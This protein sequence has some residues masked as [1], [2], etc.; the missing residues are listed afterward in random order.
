MEI[1]EEYLKQLILRAA[2]EIR[3]ERLLTSESTEKSE[4]VDALKVKSSPLTE[5][6]KPCSQRYWEQRRG[7]S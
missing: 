4:Y 2:N 7:N 5:N 1:N 3:K 6:C